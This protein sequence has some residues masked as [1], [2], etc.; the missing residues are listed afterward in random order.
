MIGNHGTFIK[1]NVLKY[2]G[3][4]KY[5]TFDGQGI[6]TNSNGIKYVGELKNGLPNGQGI[7]TL[8]DKSF[9]DGEFK[10]GEK[11]NGTLYDKDGNITEKWVNG[12]LN[13]EGYVG[14]I[15]D[16]LPHGLGTVT[17]H[18]GNKYSG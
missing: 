12:K 4:F 8:P 10:D 16:G 14:E 2:E 7:Y 15:E 1:P 5:G 11:W 17:Y 6:L 18:S 3:N 9:F 13:E